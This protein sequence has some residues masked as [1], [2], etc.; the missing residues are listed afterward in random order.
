MKAVVVAT[1]FSLIII[2]TAS[3]ANQ[4]DGGL[5]DYVNS[6]AARIEAQA[7]KNLEEFKT[8]EGR[9]RLHAEA[10]DMFGLS[11]IP[12]RGDLHATI[13]G[14][15]EDD[16]VAVEKIHFQSSPHLYV[17]AN[18]YL[19]KHIE[20]PLPTVLYVCGHAEVKT[21]GMSYGNKTAYQHHGAWFARNGYACL[22]IDTVQLGEIPGL[23]HGTYR[24]GM[25]W[26]N[27]RGYS[28]ACVEAWNCIRALDYLE[29]RP[30]IDKTRFAITGRSGG[31]AYSWFTTALDPRIRVAAPVAGITDLRNHVIDGTV[32]GHC[33]CMF[34]VNTYAWDY[35][36]LAACA[37]PRPLLIVNSDKDSIFPL[38]GVIRTHTYVANLYKFFGN[39]NDLGLVIGPGPHK[40]TQDLQVPV[41]RWFN[42][43]LRKSD[44]IIDLPATN[45]FTAA[46]LRVF[47]KLPADERN[48]TVQE[49][50][51][52]EAAPGPQIGS[53]EQW[54]QQRNEWMRGLRE[55]VFR[56]WPQSGEPTRTD[57]LKHEGSAYIV[58]DPRSISALDKKDQVQLRRRYM[59]VGTTL[60][61]M[62]VFDIVN[63][64]NSISEK[65]I[66]LE[67]RG[68]MAANAL[69]A[70][71]FTDKI[72]TL[73][74]KGLPAS[75]DRSGPDY[76]NVL[77]VLDI[78]EALA[79]AAEH[80]NLEL[81]D[82]H[83][84]LSYAELMATKLG[85]SPYLERKD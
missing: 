13:T 84:D 41:F 21:N 69:F 48:S 75:L 44:P 35:P 85:W 30:E 33:D 83:V 5:Y 40:D 7:Q 45:H 57:F 23:H 2:Q 15:I 43:Y 37:A 49:W 32:E 26:W 12:E 53:A 66:I 79:L 55:K 19:P 77:R 38:D 64:V 47:D 58:S 16:T 63:A 6:A 50:F 17:T 25:W 73:R 80:T 52:P 70:S 27:S 34:F 11:P 3:A 29:T 18:L 67:A 31:G 59:L 72:K 51:I 42:H 39:T 71:V 61:S 76:L 20:A 65:Q 4:S 54:N 10:L 36:M 8:E 82:T 60:D 46:H 62:R 28:P 78:R 14:R 24:E 1:A 9:A 81:T 74:L 68:D 22:V 56:N